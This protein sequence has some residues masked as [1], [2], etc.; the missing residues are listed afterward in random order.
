MHHRSQQYDEYID[1][2]NVLF[3]MLQASAHIAHYKD[4]IIMGTA[5]KI[6]DLIQL[7][8]WT[9]NWWAED[10]LQER[11]QQRELEMGLISLDE[12]GSIDLG[13]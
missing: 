10:Y 4:K 11:A 3:T 6:G 7:G 1:S 13:G 5:N 12:A 2:M 9:G 8:Y